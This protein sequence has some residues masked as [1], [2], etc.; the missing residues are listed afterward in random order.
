[1]SSY[2]AFPIQ[3]VPLCNQIIDDKKFLITEVFQLM[4]KEEPNQNIILC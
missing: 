3:N 2:S 4:K 1:M